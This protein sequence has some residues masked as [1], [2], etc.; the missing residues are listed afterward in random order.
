MTMVSEKV[1][2]HQAAP[3]EEH[4]NYAQ[5][6]LKISGNIGM[7]MLFTGDRDIE[8]PVRIPSVCR[9]YDNGNLRLED[10]FCLKSNDDCK[11]IWLDKLSGLKELARWR[12]I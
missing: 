2:L 12:R 1:M 7:L 10:R 9:L 5:N 3:R 4:P 8:I 6:H 11:R